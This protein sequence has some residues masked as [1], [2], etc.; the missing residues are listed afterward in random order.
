MED[1][2]DLEKFRREW[3]EEVAHRSTHR[4]PPQQR[5]TA[6]RPSQFTPTHHEASSRKDHEAE[7]PSP[8]LFDNE[9]PLARKE[10]SQ[11]VGELPQLLEHL[12]IESEHGHEEDGF[13]RRAHHEPNSALEHFERAVE[14]E[15]AG[16]LGD[17]LQ[18]YRKAYRLDASVDKTYR[19]KHFAHVWG[20]KPA[21]PKPSALEPESTAAPAPDA[22]PVTLLTSELIESF[23]NLPI[24]QA[25]PV[26]E[27]TP[28]PPC[29]IAKVPSEVLVEILR[30]VALRDP[31]NF[32]R[33]AL[34]CKKLA[35]HFAHEQHI[36]RRICQTREFG[37]QGMHYEFACDNLGQTVYTLSGKRYTPF[38]IDAPVEIP[39]PLL[40][41]SQVFQ[42]YPRI[43]FTGIYI[44]TVNY[45]RPGAVS[46][47]QS[48][49]WNNPIH[50]VT[51][52]RFLRFYPD[53]SV[54][55]L[56]T[57]TEPVDVVPYISKENIMAARATKK[58]RSAHDHGESSVGTAGTTEYVPTIAMQ[59]LKYG[60][61]GHWHLTSPVPPET[62][63]NEQITELT[64]TQ[65]HSVDPRDL[66]VETEGV[67]SRYTNLMHLSLRSPSASKSLANPSRNTKLVWKG[68][69][70][71]NKLTDDWGAFPLRNERAY[72][73]RRVRGWGLDPIDD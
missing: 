31:A 39:K 10:L 65:Q 73:F 15:A 72:V 1:N 49:S 69:W 21:Q 70:S 22:E 62:S 20:N 63:D 66:V 71:Y 27:N 52:Y 16:N 30:H 12:Q 54:V 67:D 28:P 36:W 56:L 55:S 13:T 14:K 29:P 6:P 2:A 45:T 64:S 43:R 4:A 11:Q 60:L 48:V 25:E 37:F 61:R 38:P 68:F 17:S 58:H 19:D 8:A 32:G 26:I 24:P 34:V 5:T 23:V 40:S 47:F 7:G 57:T 3:R 33:M 9:A 53:G 41:W 44:S 50:I 18:H 46:A 35:Y 59:S 51:Y 42:S